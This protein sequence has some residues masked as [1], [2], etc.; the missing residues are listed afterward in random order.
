M[1][2]LKMNKNRKIYIV[3]MIFVSLSSCIFAGDILDSY[4]NELLAKSD[5]GKDELLAV[6]DESRDKD[7]KSPENSENKKAV[8]VKKAGSSEVVK[9]DQA[10]VDK[11]TVKADNAVTTDVVKTEDTAADKKAAEKK[12]SGSAILDKSKQLRD[13]L[14]ESSISALSEGSNSS[15]NSQL[16]D[17]LAQLQSLRFSKESK[18]DEQDSQVSLKPQEPAVNPQVKSDTA[19][20]EENLENESLS[21][22]KQPLVALP[23]DSSDI[24]DVFELAESLFHIGDKANALK[25][26]RKALD[27]T[28]PLGKTANPKRA[29][30]LFQIGNCLYG[31]DGLEAIK[32]FEQL[33][34]EHPNS[35][36]T[37][38]A[39]TKK[40]V[41]KWLMVEKPSTLTAGQVK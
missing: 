18:T 22:Q 5:T 9:A 21:E 1:K 33:I 34:Q 2:C 15:I 19:E 16:Q 29:W 4:I 7:N 8:A 14:K 12:N 40:Q 31:V 38:C 20:K 32:I 25:Y 27:V 35:D 26:Y 41:L 11:K 10:P 23:D 3:L 37:N 17:V 39:R 30:I 24:V 36:W 13:K 6:L 28:L